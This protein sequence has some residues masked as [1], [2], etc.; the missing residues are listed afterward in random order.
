MT[1]DASEGRKSPRRRLLDRAIPAGLRRA[2]TSFAVQPSP[3]YPRSRL[4][5]GLAVAFFPVVG[6]I[7]GL[8]QVLVVYLGAHLW[9]ERVARCLAWGVGAGLSW[10]QV[11][12]L[13]DFCDAF[14]QRRDRE[15]SL[16]ILKDAGVG[17]LGVLGVVLVL[18]TSLTCIFE[19]PAERVFKTLWL[20][21]I[22][23]RW[24]MC[25]VLFRAVPVGPRSS[26]RPFMIG[27]TLPLFLASTTLVA[28]LSWYWLGPL[29]SAI[30]L[31]ISTGAAL[32]VRRVSM[33]RIGAVQGDALGAA[34][35]LTELGV[36][37]LAVAQAR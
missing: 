28:A 31:L 35:L 2:F 3:R 19:L 4:E 32:F 34:C 17:V 36:L 9:P 12:G 20:A 37:L 24:A 30:A 13:A 22:L 25:A 18:G 11:D 29:R 1:V 15:E 26:M 23:G 10:I 6:A 8:S 16:R 33:A 21:P 27:L 5:C 7:V 14:G